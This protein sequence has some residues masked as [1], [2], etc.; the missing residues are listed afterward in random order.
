MAD[1]NNRAYQKTEKYRKAVSDGRSKSNLPW[2][3]DWFRS[4]EP[5]AAYMV[6]YFIGDGAYHRGSNSLR[7]LSINRSILSEMR[8]T[9]KTV[10]PLRGAGYRDVNGNVRSWC[11]QISSYDLKRIFMNEFG[12]PERKTYEEGRYSVFDLIPVNSIGSFLR[13]LIDSDGCLSLM[14]LR[15]TVRFS[16][17]AHTANVMEKLKEFLDERLGIFVKVRSR[18]KGKGYVIGIA[19]RESM[20][21]IFSAIYPLGK[22]TKPRLAHSKKFNV[23]CKD[24]R[25][26]DNWG[27]EHG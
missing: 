10:L 18:G 6:G 1:M 2:H 27:L 16:Y 21:K 9:L 25:Y 5:D 12:I 24:R 11:L 7:W 8:G 22:T 3:K 15:G 14:K 19:G 13:G 4:L 26:D 17:S 23:A 20:S